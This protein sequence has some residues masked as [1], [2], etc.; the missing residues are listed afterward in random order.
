MTTQRDDVEMIHRRMAKIRGKRHEEISDVLTSAET[1]ASL[2]RKFRGYSWVA[3]SAAVA[4]V[5]WVALSRGRTRA[6]KTEM[7][8]RVDLAGPDVDHAGV[9]AAEPAPI[10]SGWAAEITN[11]LTTL[12]IRAAQNYAI[13]CV[14]EWIAPSRVIGPRPDPADI[15]KDKPMHPTADL[16]V[17]RIE[18]RIAPIPRIR[19]ASARSRSA[20]SRG[21]P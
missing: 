2:E 11:F 16:D 4:A 14:E 15:D 18:P 3:I 12:A 1:I 20:C 7:P 6:V 13:Y 9:I 8:P 5:C 17:Q 21:T 10:R 19:N